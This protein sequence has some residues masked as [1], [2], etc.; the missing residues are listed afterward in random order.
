MQKP[1]IVCVVG[2]TASGK[3]DYAIDLA[4]SRGG[5]VVSCDSMQ[6]YRYMDIGT[7][8]PPREE[9]RGVPHHMLDFVEPG[10]DYSV[11]DFVRDARACIADILARGRLPV[12]CG[13]TGL[14]VD[15]IINQIE[16][17]EE[18][19]DGALRRELKEL[20]E[21]E[22]PGAVHAILRAEDPAAA[23]AIHPNNVKRV[24]RALEIIRTTGLTKAEADR[25]ARK[26]PVYDAALFG[27]EME[28]E[29]LY[30]RIDLRVDRMME[31]GLLEEV[32]RLLDMGVPRQSTAM[33]A[34]GY[35]ELVL[36]LDGGCSLEEAVETVK[37]E[38]RR[39]AK[40][41]MTWFRRNPEI[42]WISR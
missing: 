38:S 14:Y 36:Y 12:L 34:I 29:R 10:T 19:R 23:E 4:L 1:K 18:K 20:A 11:A 30:R 41:Q 3:T 35:K 13:G 27:M 40:R 5:E 16:F 24:I 28:R 39:Y 17:A 8:K 42:Q 32:R 9:M 7:A 37:R 21:R 6:I 25:R 26:E 31:Q 2:P 15:S 22:G 33:Q